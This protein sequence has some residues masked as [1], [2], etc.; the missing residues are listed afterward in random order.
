[1]YLWSKKSGRASVLSVSSCNR[2]AKGSW[3]HSQNGEINHLDFGD[4]N[5]LFWPSFDWMYF[6]EEI[7]IHMDLQLREPLLGGSSI[8]GKTLCKLA[9]FPQEL[10]RKVFHSVP[11]FIPLG[12]TLALSGSLTLSYLLKSTRSF[13]LKIWRVLLTWVLTISF[14]HKA[15]FF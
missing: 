14:Q 6:L 13:S 2:V 5:T 7:K 8:G 11:L 15:K 3:K 4:K 10:S 1:M 9:F 12:L